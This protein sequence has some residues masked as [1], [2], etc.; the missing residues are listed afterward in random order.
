MGMSIDEA[1]LE[2]RWLK[3]IN[4]EIL[5]TDDADSAWAKHCESVTQ[6]LDIAI[7]TARKYQMMQA[8]YNARLKADMVAMCD[9]PSGKWIPVNDPY[10][11]LPK[12]D[13]WVTRCNN[14][15]LC[16]DR[17]YYDMTE[18]NDYI[19]DVVAYMDYVKPEPYQPVL[20]EKTDGNDD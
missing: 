18:W 13:L 11:E 4:Q 7:D 15:N 8:D 14:E 3:K 6:A 1:V 17:I 9:K 20:K 16:V 19:G 2:L 12:K 5:E 10:T